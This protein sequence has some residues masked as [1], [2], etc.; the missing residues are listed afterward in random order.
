MN[1]ALKLREEEIEF[2]LVGKGRELNW[3][4]NFVK[5]NELKNVK[6]VKPVPLHKLSTFINLANVCLGLFGN[7]S[8]ARKVIPTKIFEYS[9]MKKPIISAE[10]PAIK[11]LFS[12]KKNI[13]LCEPE[14]PNALAN[15]ILELKNNSALLKKISKN[16]YL[17][18][19]SNA[20]LEILSRQIKKVLVE[21][22]ICSGKNA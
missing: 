6:F 1:A 19:K 2:V 3:C 7:S 5:K 11:E 15:A 21:A 8:K 22:G 17:T 4:K 18:F 16:A 12:H 9:A 13:F 20:S 14:N 10:T